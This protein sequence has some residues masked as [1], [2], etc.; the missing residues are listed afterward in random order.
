MIPAMRGRKPKPISLQISEGDTRRRGRL[1][2]STKAIP[3][4]AHG[5]PDC[6]RYLRG[7]ARGAWNLWRAELE[8]MDLDAA[9]DA[10]TLA[11]ACMNYATCVKA[12]LKI[13]QQGEVIEEPIIARD[14]GKVLGSRIK[15]NPWVAIRADA[16]RLLLAF[17]S[18]F[19][20][21]PAARTRLS[22]TAPR[23]TDQDI[24]ALL[25]GPRLTD[26][27]KRKMLQQ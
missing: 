13:E 17:A 25:N 9:V 4:P 3:Q 26:E 23:N 21:A 1:K 24:E 6:P 14:S 19:G 18:E 10:M 15:K 27:Q 8:A 2:L 12:H 7:K 5:L 11:A 16:H 22:V 20:L